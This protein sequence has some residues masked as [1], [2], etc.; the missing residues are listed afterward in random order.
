MTGLPRALVA[1]CRGARHGGPKTQ[2]NRRLSS[3][4]LAALIAVIA[5]SS[6]RLSDSL[7]LVHRTPST[8]RRVEA[9]RN[10]AR[11]PAA[12]ARTNLASSAGPSDG[13]DASDEGGSKRTR[14]AS[15][16]ADTPGKART[17]YEVLGAD[18]ADTRAQ[19]KK[20]YA[21][22]ARLS[23]P[24]AKIRRTVGGG[25]DEQ[26][27]GAVDFQEVAEAWRILGDSKLRRR[28]DRE[29]QAKA[30]S[31]K[32]QRYTNERLE[33]AVPVALDMMD[34]VAFPFLRRTTA[35]TFA[36]G[37]AIATG[38]SGNN[39]NN[40]NAREGRNNQ[41]ANGG[42]KD[43][44][45]AERNNSP[46]SLTEAF[47]SAIEAGQQAGRVIDSLELNEKSDDLEKR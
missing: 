41:G 40:S 28:Y 20:Q 2:M 24:D 31:E 15:H 23:H 14:R 38:L 32:A 37:H 5:A 36:V 27:E 9:D 34:K 43:G 18:P 42:Q 11:F 3:A 33:R 8:P 25:D 30:W 19:L 4:L 26:E 35:T 29:L 16:E 7:I 6:L 13:D 45:F 46:E 44:S 22:M 39:R 12:A 10:A 17:L 21:V 1:D 47:M